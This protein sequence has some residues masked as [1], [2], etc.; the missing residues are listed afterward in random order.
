[1]QWEKLNARIHN[2]FYL[3]FFCF[4]S[5]C[6]AY[7]IHDPRIQSTPKSHWIDSK[8]KCLYTQRDRFRFV[9]QVMMF[10]TA[11]WTDSWLRNLFNTTFNVH[12]WLISRVLFSLPFFSLL[13]YLFLCTSLLFIL[14]VIITYVFVRFSTCVHK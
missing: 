3:F 10:M 1:M 5:L 6:F 13:F 14:I 9:M 12:N 8:S 4:S 2:N 7:S 11:V